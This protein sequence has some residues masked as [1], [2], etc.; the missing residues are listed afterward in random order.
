MATELKPQSANR[1]TSAKLCCALSAAPWLRIAAAGTLIAG[2]GLLLGGKQKAGLATASAGAAL[3]LLD[4]KETVLS[5]WDQLPG[6]IA[7][8]QQLLGQ[9]QETLDG[10]AT[11]RDQIARILGR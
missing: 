6:R 2:G 1:S 9:L 4:Q 11:Q 3:A 5:C 8:F 7:Q 10:V